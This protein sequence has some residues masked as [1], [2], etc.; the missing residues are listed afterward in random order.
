MWQW[1]IYTTNPNSTEIVTML[2]QNVICQ[3]PLIYTILKNTG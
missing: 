2:Q 3:E 1:E